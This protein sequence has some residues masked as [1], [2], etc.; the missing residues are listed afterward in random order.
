MKSIISTDD[1]CYLCG[2]RQWIEIHHV[3]VGSNRDTSDDY[4]LTVP[5]CHYCHNEPPYGVHQNRE[6]REALQAAVQ[7][8]AME[9]YGWS[10]EDFRKRFH[11]SYL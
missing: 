11:K 3:Y 10:E 9:Y 2:S 4:G 5:L 6:R 7:K 8:K 1:R